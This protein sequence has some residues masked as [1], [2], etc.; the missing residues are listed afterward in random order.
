MT[1]GS[2]EPY[3]QQLH[4]NRAC[5]GSGAPGYAGVSCGASAMNYGGSGLAAGGVTPQH[6]YGVRSRGA[7]PSQGGAAVYTSGAA[8]DGTGMP[9]KSHMRG[10]HSGC[11]G[12]G[13]TTSWRRDA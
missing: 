8:P 13:M 1:I 11:D 10:I 7:T 9:P 5:M 4:A 3:L 12:L 6:E 2:D